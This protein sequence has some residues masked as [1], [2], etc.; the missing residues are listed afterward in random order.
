MKTWPHAPSKCVTDPGTYII[1]G[2]TYRKQRLFD[3]DDKL[4]LLHD[5]VLAVAEELGWQLQAWAVFTNH[6]HVV[7]FSPNVE[8]PAEAFSKLLYGRTSFALNQFDEARGRQ[9]WYRAWDTRLTY[10]KS[11]LARLA[12]VHTN[13]IKHGLVADATRYPWCSANW[14][15]TTGHR[16]FVETVLS[17]KTDKVVVPD[18]FD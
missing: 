17:F 1:T 16:P 15:A 4:E 18:D 10:E 5:T 3:T 6:Y 12:Y 7:G 9:V 13:P 14:F 2:S 11:Y 8:K